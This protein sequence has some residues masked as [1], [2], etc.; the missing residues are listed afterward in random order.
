MDKPP[1]V[2][3]DCKR[4]NSA[5][6]VGFMRMREAG[7]PVEVN[8]DGI[9]L[10][11]TAETTPEA[12]IDQYFD[13]FLADCR[14][15]EVPFDPAAHRICIETYWLE[16]EKGTFLWEALEEANRKAMRSGKSVSLEFNGVSLTVGG[17]RQHGELVATYFDALAAQQGTKVSPQERQQQLE[18]Y[19]AAYYFDDAYLHQPSP[20]TVRVV[21]RTPLDSAQGKGDGTFLNL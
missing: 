12:L 15:G 7:E 19:Y 17:E 10:T 18:Q 1:A 2:E 11:V 8:F 16:D 3:N 9:T 20:A 4:L 13:E 5:I 6:K 21:T 14:D